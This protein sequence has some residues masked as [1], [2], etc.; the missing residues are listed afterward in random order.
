M[1]LRR[2]GSIPQAEV[3]LDSLTPGENLDHAAQVC[4]AE[5]TP[6]GS[7]TIDRKA[8]GTTLTPPERRP[9]GGRP[10]WRA[11]EACRGGC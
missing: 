9:A 5:L 11:T 7:G 8:F 2:V 4:R 3:P 1:Y 10:Q 6:G